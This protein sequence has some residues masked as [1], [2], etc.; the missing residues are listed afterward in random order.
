MLPSYLQQSL[1]SDDILTKSS[2]EAKF[3]EITMTT[4]A[5]KSGTNSTI[6]QQ[7]Q[8][9]PESSDSSNLVRYLKLPEQNMEL[10]WMLMPQ[11]DLNLIK[12]NN[13]HKSHWRPI[14]ALYTCFNSFY[15][16]SLSSISYRRYNRTNY[17]L[18]CKYLIK[19]VND[20]LSGK[21]RI[22]IYRRLF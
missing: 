22:D 20:K 10:I 16:R 7:Q 18:Y 3:S 15:K 2:R 5:E 17:N 4:F 9:R 19:T 12:G 11:N 8:Q 13:N 1:S 14:Y 6:Q 21:F